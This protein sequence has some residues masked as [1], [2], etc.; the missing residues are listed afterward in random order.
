MKAVPLSCLVVALALGALGAC[1]AARSACSTASCPASTVCDFD[2]TCRALPDPAQAA[3]FSEAD[4][5][6]PL[7]WNNPTRALRHRPPGDRLLLGGDEGAMVDLVFA[8]PTHR[9]SVVEAV[10]V[11]FPYPNARSTSEPGTL[12]VTRIRAAEALNPR[13]HTP[14]LRIGRT[15]AARVETPSARQAIRL[16]VTQAAQ[17]TVGARLGLRVRMARGGD[18]TAW[19]LASPE[20]LDETLRP[21]I[22]LLLR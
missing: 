18:D 21:R 2:G 15:L 3:T 14:L 7:G 1:G 19:L 16:D 11:L 10:L 12:S 9:R 17:D 22:E 20:S 13:R 5:V 4:V 8:I 6:Y